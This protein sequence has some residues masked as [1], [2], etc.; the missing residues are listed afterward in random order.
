M[1]VDVEAVL[2]AAGFP[3]PPS[4]AKDGAPYLGGSW[5]LGK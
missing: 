4:D 1:A 2:L 5:G 3:D